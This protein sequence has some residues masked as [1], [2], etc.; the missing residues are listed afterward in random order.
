MTIVLDI[1][2]MDTESFQIDA[3]RN[4]RDRYPDVTFVMT[5]CFFPSKDGRNGQRLEYMKTLAADRFYFDFSNL[6]PCVAPEPYPFV[7]QQ[8]FLREAKKILG[9]E[10]M[11]WG[12]DL[13]SVFNRYT[14]R[15]LIDYVTESDIFT[16]AELPLVM[17]E[18]AVR[19][20]HIDLPDAAA[21]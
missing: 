11:I 8:N 17:A 20:Y 3:V 14:Y 19:V 6:P 21:R 16:P 4:I 15:E 7:S 12:T 18:N 5:H 10:H 9:A 13:P 2:P 1:G